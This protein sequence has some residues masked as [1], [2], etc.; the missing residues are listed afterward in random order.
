[1]ENTVSLFRVIAAMSIALLSAGCGAAAAPSRPVLTGEPAV[2]S[3]P[4]VSPATPSSPS[5]SRGTAS[6]RIAVVLGRSEVDEIILTLKPDGSDAWQVATDRPSINEGPAWIPGTST[7]VFDSDRA[8]SIDLFRTDVG[9]AAVTA[10]TKTRDGL[11]GFASV[12]PDGMTIA[13][14]NSTSS[15][16]LGIWLMAIDGSHARRLVRPPAPPAFDSAP[17]FSPDGSMVAFSRKRDQRA[18]HAQEAAFVIRADGSG[19]RQLT[20]CDLDV[21]RIR[22]APDGSHLVFSDNAENRP[23]DGAVDL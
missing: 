2:S 9:S 5:P 23:I 1:V 4:S 15:R 3:H 11:E 12:S 6:G 10:I 20:D 18:P 16:S 17:A 8:G 13:F 7:V 21:A 19:L 14:D 22:W